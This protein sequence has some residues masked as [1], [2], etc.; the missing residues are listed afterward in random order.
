MLK[1]LQEL[2]E[3]SDSVCKCTDLRDDLS[4]MLVVMINIMK[5]NNLTIDNCLEKAYNDIKDRKGKMIDRRSICKTMK[6]T[7]V[8]PTDPR[9]LS[10]IALFEEKKLKEDDKLSPKEFADNMFET[11]TSYNNINLSVNQCGKP[12]RMFVMNDHPSIEKIK[13]ECVIIQR[14]EDIVKKQLDSK[15]ESFLTF[16]LFVFRYRKT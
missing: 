10:S 5:R 11:M 1:L 15:E 16:P 6:Y 8:P 13:S 9:V 14:L 2:G 12:Y 3:L 4:D 7:L